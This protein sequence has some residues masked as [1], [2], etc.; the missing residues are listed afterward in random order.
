MSNSASDSGS[1]RWCVWQ[2]KMNCSFSESAR[3]WA[4]S[5]VCASAQLTRKSGPKTSFIARKDAAMPEAVWKKRR[6][7]NP[8]RFAS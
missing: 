3:A 8:C 1:C 4:I 2:S 6:R 7:V 5:G